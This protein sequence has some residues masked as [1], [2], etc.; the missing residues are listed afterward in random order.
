MGKDNQ[1]AQHQFT[2]RAQLKSCVFRSIAAVAVPAVAFGALTLVY[3]ARQANEDKSLRMK[4]I[5]KHKT[6]LSTQE[7]EET[8]VALSVAPITGR[9]MSSSGAPSQS[10]TSSSDE[11]DTAP[12][13]ML[14]QPERPEPRIPSRDEEAV[15]SQSPDADKHS[16]LPPQTAVLDRPDRPEPERSHD[17]AADMHNDLTQQSGAF[18]WSRGEHHDSA[19]P[20]SPANKEEVSTVKSM[21]GWGRSVT[22][23][24]NR[25][26]QC[27]CAVYTSATATKQDLHELPQACDT[28]VA[29]FEIP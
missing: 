12:P 9:V 7:E 2:S 4:A 1:G 16:K 5:D 18:A 20:S 25:V 24:L 19:R 11:P 15:P 13:A 26:K 6:F 23:S 8:E 28:I 17:D 10:S 21:L 14:D 22:A 27:T 29:H 3:Q